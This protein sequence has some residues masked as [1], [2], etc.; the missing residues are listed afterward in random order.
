MSRVPDAAV[1]SAVVHAVATGVAVAAQ[2]HF[3]VRVAGP[4]AVPC[5]QG[6]VT[7]DLVGSRPDS[8]Q[9]AATL[10]PKGMVV[11]DLW[12]ARAGDDAWITTWE[13][14]HDA[15]ETVFRTYLP[16]RLAK[17]HD[18]SSTYT[19]I[20]MTGPGAARLVEACGFPDPPAGSATAIDAQDEHAFV[21]QP[22]VLAPFDR[23]ML[24]P[25]NSAPAVMQR[26]AEHG[27]T[28]VSP[29]SLELVRIQ[30]GYP[31]FGCEIDE[32][33]LPQEIRMD[34]HLGIS[35][36]K[37]CYTG[38]ETVARLHFRGHA[39]RSL[40]G[41]QWDREPSAEGN[42]VT[43]DGTTVGRV[44]SVIR[45]PGTSRFLG[46]AIVHRKADLDRPLDACGTSAVAA[47][48]PQDLDAR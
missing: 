21:M 3:A 2:P 31:R 38:Q 16:P 20:R 46:L 15:L 48:L 12:I 22:A 7:Q 25:T 19:T 41:V 23:Q 28:L 17:V 33:V 29:E 40:I 42:A 47:P 1:D 24:V 30:R 9:Y 13:E 32:R 18:L 27:G 36:E 5:V 8:F 11:S 14:A 34:E 44:G 45:V 39:N 6:I 10:T 35:Y 4:G 37:G 43:Q 26:L